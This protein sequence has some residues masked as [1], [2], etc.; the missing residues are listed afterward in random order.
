MRPFRG[1]QMRNRF[2]AVSISLQD[3]DRA[4]CICIIVVIIALSR[5]HHRMPPYEA[6]EEMRALFCDRWN[7]GMVEWW[8]GGMVLFFPLEFAAFQDLMTFTRPSRSLTTTSN[9]FTVALPTFTHTAH[10]LYFG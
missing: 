2:P 1:T 7:G 5:H 8:N 4:I 3:S 10:A 6:F 9:S